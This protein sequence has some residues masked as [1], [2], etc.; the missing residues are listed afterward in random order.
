MH[1]QEVRKIYMQDIT[2][3]YNNL[4]SKYEEDKNA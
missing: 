4:L 1:E 2:K 3:K